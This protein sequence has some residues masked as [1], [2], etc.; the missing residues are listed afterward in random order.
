[1]TLAD[2]MNQ[3][4]LTDVYTIFHLNTKEYTFFSVPHGSFSK[5]DRIVSENQTSTDTR[6]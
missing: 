4:D 5:T 3:I 1:M 2:I 6:K